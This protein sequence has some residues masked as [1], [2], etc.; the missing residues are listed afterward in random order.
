MAK[1]KPAAPLDL[2]DCVPLP[3]AARLADVSER[4][5]RLLVEKGQVAAVKIGRNYLVSRAAAQGF[6]RHPS[7]GRPRKA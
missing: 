7:A 1:K 2:A 6:Q 3:E 4:H 5:M